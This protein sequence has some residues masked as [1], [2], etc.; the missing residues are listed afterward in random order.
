MSDVIS[1]FGMELGELRVLL[2]QF[3]TSTRTTGGELDRVRGLL[4]QG[5]DQVPQRVE[6]CHNDLRGL[7]SGM[8]AHN[9]NLASQRDQLGQACK[10]SIA[11]TAER[12][13]RVDAAKGEAIS[14]L[15]EASA[16]CTAA[17][18][19]VAAEAASAGAAVV[20]LA[21]TCEQ[22]RQGYDQDHQ[23]GTKQLTQIQ[24]HTEVQKKDLTTRTQTAESESGAC[25]AALKNG[26]SQVLGPAFQA[27]EKALQALQAEVGEALHKDARSWSAAS[28]ALIKDFTK[29]S[30]HFQ[31]AYKAGMTSVNTA[32]S[33][34]TDGINSALRGQV[35][36]G[37]VSLQNGMQGSQTCLPV[38]LDKSTRLASQ[39]PPVASN[40]A[41]LEQLLAQGGR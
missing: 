33:E 26:E 37:L 18:K 15:T 25:L 27:T 36:P 6:A 32:S 31:D 16:K 19:Q 35:N 23:Q 24:A 3:L 41:T 17:A 2:E 13:G 20:N 39:F 7:G 5:R 12:R 38:A 29:Q 11:Q 21:R 9:S 1:T 10:T 30:Q 28:D 8:Q 14:Q 4:E 34:L 22:V 40:Q